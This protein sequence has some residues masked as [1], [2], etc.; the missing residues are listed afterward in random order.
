MDGL[1]GVAGIIVKIAIVDH[2][3][4]FPT[5]RTS[6]KKWKPNQNISRPYCCYGTVPESMAESNSFGNSFSN[7]QLAVDS[8]RDFSFWEMDIKDVNKQQK[9]EPVGCWH[10]LITAHSH[11]RMK[12]VTYQPFWFNT[13]IITYQQKNV[14]SFV[15][16]WKFRE[17]LWA[18]SHV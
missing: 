17:T 12:T 5:K 14:I 15:Q 18:R 3:R 13:Q 7:V 9:Q 4:K 11:D 8:S 6:K 16:Q 1:L 2:S 10:P